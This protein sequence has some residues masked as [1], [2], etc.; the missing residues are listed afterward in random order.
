MRRFVLTFGLAG[1]AMGC[2]RPSA[3]PATSADAS[4]AASSSSGAEAAAPA[5]L[6]PDGLPTREPE[7]GLVLG[8]CQICHTAEYVKQQRLSPAQWTATVNKMIGWGAPITPEQGAALAQVLA[9]A[10]PPDLA[11]YRAPLVETPGVKR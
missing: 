1:A 3:P 8:Q 11:E 5:V 2:T 4:H 7:R 6:D 10:Y 9:E